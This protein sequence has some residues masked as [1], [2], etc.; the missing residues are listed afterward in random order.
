MHLELTNKS[1]TVRFLLS[2]ANVIV[3]YTPHKKFTSARTCNDN[4]LAVHHKCV[5]LF[6]LVPLSEVTRQQLQ[7]EK[8]LLLWNT[9]LRGFLPFDLNWLS[10][11]YRGAV[12]EN[13]VS[14]WLFP[15]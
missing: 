5:K 9:G 3:I 11:F 1:Y 15:L 10:E 4:T 8:G 14:L 12:T 2:L 6:V 7:L 13:I